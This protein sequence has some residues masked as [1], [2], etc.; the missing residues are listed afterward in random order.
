M[1]NVMS[2]LLYAGSSRR[3][4]TLAINSICLLCTVPQE[5]F[6]LIEG[7]ASKQIGTEILNSLVSCDENRLIKQFDQLEKAIDASADPLGES[8]AFLAS[9]IEQM[10]I[11]YG[12]NLTIQD[13]CALVRENLHALQLPVEA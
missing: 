1:V 12:L 13:A 6:C 8:R 3:I 10:N 2:A 9:F 11:Q 7:S 4:S 5:S